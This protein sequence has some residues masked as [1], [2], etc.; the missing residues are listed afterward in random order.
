LG[1]DFAGPVTT[2][3]G[4]VSGSISPAPGTRVDLVNTCGTSAPAAT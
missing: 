3:F 1:L 4:P 2:G